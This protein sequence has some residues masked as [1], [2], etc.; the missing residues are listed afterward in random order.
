MEGIKKKDTVISLA[1]AQ[2]S[3]ACSQ[4]LTDE[5][6][7]AEERERRERQE[8]GIDV[9]TRLK[10]AVFKGR[11][12][13]DK[14]K[15]N[16]FLAMELDGRGTL[17]ANEDLLLEEFFKDPKKYIEDAEYWA[18]YRHP[19]VTRG[20]RGL[21]GMKWIWK[22]MYAGLTKMVWKIY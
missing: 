12:R 2:I 1:R 4:V 3:T 16:D 14:M 17:G 15:L 13:V 21:Y 11:V 5:R 7:E 20:W 10:Y 18:K 9:S 19:I 22:R 6:R 8:L